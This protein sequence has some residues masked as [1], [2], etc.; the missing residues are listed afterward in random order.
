MHDLQTVTT[1]STVVL[2]ACAVGRPRTYR[3][4]VSVGLPGVLLAGGAKRV[5]AAEVDVPD[6]ATLEVMTRFYEAAADGTSP[7][8]GLADTFADLWEADRWLGATAAAFN[9]YGS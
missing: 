7:G 2:S 4:G 9:V 1:P 6:E 3:G 8:R 5:V